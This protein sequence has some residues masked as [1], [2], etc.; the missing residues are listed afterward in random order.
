[1]V[2]LTLATAHLEL[3]AATPETALAETTGEPQWWRRLGASGPASWPPPLNDG[4]ALRWF[5]E[6]IAIDPEG[7][8]WYTWYVLE[9]DAPAPRRLIG[10]A[11][12]TGRPDA[13]GSAE[14]GYSI[15]P[16]HQR[17]GYGTELVGALIGWA[18]AQRCVQR[19][20]AETYPDFIAS[21][22]VLEKNGF[23]IAGRA[24]RPGAIRFELRRTVFLQRGGH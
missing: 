18:F 3:I 10:N 1:M 22:R 5:A 4:E 20:M 23:R 6:S 21:V 15:L 8:G 2:T 24:V 11:G 14:I 9:R 12:F 17:R 16:A 13:H 7:V 19:V